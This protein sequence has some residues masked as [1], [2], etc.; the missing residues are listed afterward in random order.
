MTATIIRA[1]SQSEPGSDGGSDARYTSNM[2]VQLHA[3][4]LLALPFATAVAIA[5][6]ARRNPTSREL[7][8]AMIIALP[9]MLLVSLVNHHACGEGLPRGQWL[10]GG[11]CMLLV[12]AAVKPA[13]WRRMLAGLLFVSM[14]GLSCH[15]TDIVHTSG[16]TGNPGWEIRAN[17]DRRSLQQAVGQLALNVEDPAATYDAGWLR[18]LPVWEDVKSL[19]REQYSPQ[20]QFERAWHTGLTGLYRYTLVPQ[21]VWYPGGIFK[22]AVGRIE[23]RDRPER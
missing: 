10:V 13:L 12:L 17:S 14:V 8:T 7:G 2:L 3:A 23:L 18:E 22:E 6:L 11:L 20:R 15:F 5:V 21:D 4:L 9:A 1:T 19:L 16:W